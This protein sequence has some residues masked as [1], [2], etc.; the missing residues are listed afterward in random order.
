LFLLPDQNRSAGPWGTSFFVRVRDPND[1][2]RSLVYL[3]TVKHVLQ[4]EGG[5]PWLSKIFLR[6]NTHKA[7]IGFNNALRLC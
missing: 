6:L 7:G 2:K 4:T 5:Q 1:E 3:V